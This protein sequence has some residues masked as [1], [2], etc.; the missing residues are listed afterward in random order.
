VGFSFAFP[1]RFLVTGALLN[2]AARTMAAIRDGAMLVPCSDIAST[3]TAAL[4]FAGNGPR[5]GR[6]EGR[7]GADPFDDEY[8]SGL[9]A[10][11]PC[12]MPAIRYA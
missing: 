9:F 10:C 8:L 5:S 11:P 12:G 6:L 2:N 7:N 4:R 3:D 1:A